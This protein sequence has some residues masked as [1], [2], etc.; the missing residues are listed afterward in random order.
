MLRAHGNASAVVLA[1][2]IEAGFQDALAASF[3]EAPTQRAKLEVLENWKGR[4]QPGSVLQTT[5]STRIGT[6]GMVVT[7]GEVYLLYLHNQEPYD[8][9]L[10]RRSARLVDASADIEILRSRFGKPSS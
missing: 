9:A 2:A 1:K 8:L 3:G 10:S 4:H 5:M 6:C 7:P